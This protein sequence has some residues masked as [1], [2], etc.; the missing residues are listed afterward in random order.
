VI[1]YRY[2][3]LHKVSHF[4]DAVRFLQTR[5]PMKIY[6]S[7]TVIW[8]G[9]QYQKVEEQS[10]EY[11]GPVAHACGA[12]NAQNE[13]EQATTQAYQ[14]AVNQAQQVFG[15]SSTAFNDLVKSYQPI[16]AAGPS[17]LGFSQQELAAD[18]SQ[19]ITQTGIEAKNEKAALGNSEA[20]QVGT[21]GQ[22]PV[23]PG[24]ATVGANASLVENAGNQT[25][26][27]LS[28]IQQADFATGRQNYQ[29][30][31]QGLAGATSVFNPATSATSA[32]TGAGES[33]TTATQNVASAQ[34]SGWQLAAGA[35]GGIAGA[36]LGN[37]G[38]LTK[39]VAGGNGTQG[40][41]PSSDDG[42]SGG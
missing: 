21:G 36:A 35:L 11:V 20:T 23:G 10:Y 9:T 42:Y 5:K 12:T 33:A 30:A 17:Q 24:G 28:Q 1:L 14:T 32:A 18:N 13:Q 3:D 39:L 29:A 6:T 37:G 15:A 7:L 41:G 19:A 31:V 25:A 8:T 26:S 34:Q 16:V 27:E 22:G 40:K 38:A 4:K 2:E